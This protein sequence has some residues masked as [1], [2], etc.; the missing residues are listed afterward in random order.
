MAYDRAP[1]DVLNMSVP[2]ANVQ[3][4]L[5]ADAH[6]VS[7]PIAVDPHTVTAAST[8]PSSRVATVPFPDA[9][10]DL[11]LIIDTLEHVLDDQAALNEAARV[12]RPGGHIMLRVPN[13][14]CLAWLDS[15]NLFRYF[16]ALT[17]GERSHDAGEIGWRRH[18]RAR[19]IAQIL[20]DDRFRLTTPRGSGLGLAEPLNL[21]LLVLF[22]RFIPQRQ[23][24]RRVRP[25]YLVAVNVDE[26]I[27]SGRQGWRKTIVA[28]LRR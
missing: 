13:A 15:L 24:Y 3:P 26:R 25:L 4:F 16:Q 9:S 18:Y 10:F 6:V 20:P 17:G 19:D 27:P 1:V 2:D 5:P 22:R 7:Y 23:L 14:G 8:S 21:A 12:T 28:E 11:V